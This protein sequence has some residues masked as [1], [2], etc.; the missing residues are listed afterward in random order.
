MSDQSEPI[1]DR[2]RQ[3][4]QRELADL[5]TQRAELAATLQDPEGDGDAVDHADRER[6]AM[7]LGPIEERIALL[8][9]RLRTADTGG[10]SVEVIGV[11]STATVRFA[12]GSVATVEVALIDDQS[13]PGLVTADSPLGRALAGHRA[14][15]TV[16]YDAPAGA[17][18]A[19][20]LSVG[21][22]SAAG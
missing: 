21:G 2:E 16:R 20:V 14:G 10:P 9:D 6:R 15:D 5:H 3:A 19:V 8:T 17:Q 7:N 12:D 11:G 22:D 18:T 4:V 13:D 1:G